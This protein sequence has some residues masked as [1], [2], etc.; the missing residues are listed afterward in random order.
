M[1][2]LT[3]H[4]TLN[5]VYE[6]PVFGDKAV[7]LKTFE[8]TNGDSTLLEIT[9]APGGGN[10]M[11]FHLDFSETFRPITGALLVRIGHERKLLQPGEVCT[12]PVKTPHCFQNPSKETIVFQVEL[13]PGHPGFE[14]SLKIAYGLAKDGLTNQKS[15]PKKFSHLALLATMSGTFPVGIFSLL[16]PLL[17]WKAK[18]A[19]KQ[20]V[21]QKLIDTYCR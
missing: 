5:R 15:L 9:L 7:F 19:R 17:Q 8:E 16:M 1:S 14:N 13:Q 21:E 2:H 3:T 12:V 20:G 10:A 18:R 6:N 11:H 4:S